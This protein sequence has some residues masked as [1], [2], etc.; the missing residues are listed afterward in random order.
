MNNITKLSIIGAIIVSIFSS[1]THASHA[2]ENIGDFIY[3]KIL[4][5]YSATSTFYNS[6]WK[7]W[8][9]YDW[10]GLKQL[11]VTNLIKSTVTDRLKEQIDEPRPNG[12]GNDSFP[13]GHTSN[14]FAHAAFI[15]RRYGLNQAIIP[16][17]L[18][19]FVGYSRIQ[20]KWHYTHYVIAGAAIGFLSA[21]IF[22]SPKQNIT[23]SADTNGARI[24]FYTTF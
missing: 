17:T 7:T 4:P 20:S 18:A 21:W 11:I 23:L 5:V 6:D 22:A 19:T 3:F 1:P 2:I 16:Y 8:H 9:D 15:H 24:D 10:N 14:A 13:S 12:K